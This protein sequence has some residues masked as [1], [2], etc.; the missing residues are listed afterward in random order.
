MDF[1][2][3]VYFGYIKDSRAALRGVKC[4]LCCVSALAE[5][6]GSMLFSDCGSCKFLRHAYT[7]DNKARLWHRGRV[8]NLWLEMD[9][10]DFLR[11]AVMRAGSHVKSIRR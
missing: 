5:Q 10:P 3:K 2:S 11:L 8:Q 7:E 1:F 6:R 4:L 9:L